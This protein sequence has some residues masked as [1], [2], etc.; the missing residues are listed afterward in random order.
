MIL[1]TEPVYNMVTQKS[2]L[3]KELKATRPPTSPVN[4][5]LWNFSSQWFL[6]PQGTGII[7]VILYNLDYQFRGLEIISVIAWI[8]TIALLIVFSLVYLLRIY[9]YPR[10]VARV[11][12]TSIIETSGLASISI[13][14]TT[15]IQMTV[16]VLVPQWGPSFGHIAHVLWWINTAMA[17]IATI[18]I[19]Y[20]YVKVQP[21]GIDAVPP[22]VL[23]PLIAALTS[24]AGAGVLCNFGS[25]SERLQVPVIVV[26]YLE[27]G[28]GI[29]LALSFSNIFLARLFDK[30]FLNQPLVYQDMILCGPFGQGSFALVLL[31]KAVMDGSFAQY[32]RGD[33][34]SSAAAIPIAYVSQFLGLLTWGYGTFWWCFAVISIVHTLL[35]QPGGWRKTEYSMAAWALVFPMVRFYPDIPCCC[36][37]VTLD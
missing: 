36:C 29:P 27:V 7:A 2:T 13:A 22:V 31:G 11:L 25:I 1:S 19:P 8:Y 9:C 30:S 5:A 37:F 21:P 12:R 26:A 18:G 34:I 23:L 15:I 20:V 10:H 17:V 14:F 3:E 32:D 35:A 16:L 28:L 6:I 24:A 4:R 33:F